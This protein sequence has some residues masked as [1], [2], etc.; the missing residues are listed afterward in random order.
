MNAL[1]ARNA[2]VAFANTTPEDMSVLAA[3]GDERIR[4]DPT[5]KRNR[6]GTALAPTP[7]EVALSSSTA[8][9]ITPNALSAVRKAIRSMPTD[10]VGP[11]PLE[12]W[13]DSLRSRIL[14]LF[15]IRGASVVFAG[16]GTETELIAL[17]IAKSIFAGRLANIVVAPGET[18]SGVIQAAAGNHFLESTPFGESHRV[19][20]PLQGWRQDE[21]EAIGVDIRDPNG[22]LRA[23]ADI[24]AEAAFR[25]AAAIEAGHNVLLH[26]LETSKTGQTGVSSAGIA[27]ITA[28]APGRVL[29]M[30]DC[31]QMRCS[32]HRIRLFLQRGFM[33]AITGSK[34][35]GGPPF[36]GALL[37]PSQISQR[38]NELALPIGLADYSSRLDWPR[39][40]RPKS[41]FQWSNEANIGLGLRWVAALDE[42]ERFYFPPA[43]LREEILA[44]FERQIMEQLL[45]NDHLLVPCSHH[46]ASGQ[47]QSIFSLIMHHPDRAPF[48]RSETATVH[49]RLKLPSASQAGLLSAARVFNLGQP[50]AIGRKHALRVCVSA[51]MISDIADCVQAGE[52]LEGAFAQWRIDI[53]ALF[54]K[55]RWLMKMASAR[56]HDG[57]SSQLGFEPNR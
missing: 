8:S 15:G 35:F 42:M 31:C 40:M 41:P 3:G 10:A 37:I 30:V 17:A 16:S 33:V 44:R 43:E 22:Q 55:W 11:Y 12:R 26:R 2:E 29:V 18:G 6:Y 7:G 47:R 32:R 39:K 24:D 9:T 45:V 1:L 13:F 34:F 27:Q 36:S 57:K 50:V 5:T 23:A 20:R 48:S 46:N 19:G 51:P 53:E 25:A 28:A 38:L 56:R 49:A 14:D 21:V 54:E 52:S 4:V